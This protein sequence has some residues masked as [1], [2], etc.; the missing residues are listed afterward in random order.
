MQRKD[1]L[2]EK[3]KEGLYPQNIIEEAIVYV[4]SFR[5]IDDYDYAYQYIF[6]HKEA[7]T[8][9]K[10]EEK[11][12]QKGISKDVLQKVLEDSYC[13]EEYEELELKQAHRLLQK[14]H[15]DSESMDWKEKQKIYSYLIRKGISTSIAKKSM[16]IGDK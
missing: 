9:R 1:K 12:L 7:E 8:K 14:K 4:K 15:Y 16:S 2:R 3:L 5:Y 13:E 11:L 10:I 6:Y